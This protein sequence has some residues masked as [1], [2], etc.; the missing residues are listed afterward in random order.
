MSPWTTELA[1]W[2]ALP[3]S[4]LDRISLSP[5]F[6]AI[7]TFIRCDHD[8]LTT[9]FA[10]GIFGD[11]HLSIEQRVLGGPSY[12]PGISLGPPGSCGLV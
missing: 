11:L 5:A 4:A 12:H 1:D 9:I 3:N 10:I 8:C 6:S 2:R 7:A